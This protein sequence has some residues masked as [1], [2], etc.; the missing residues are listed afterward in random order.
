MES[1]LTRGARLGA[2]VGPAGTFVGVPG[3]APDNL[4]R[5]A[6]AQ[7]RSPA[8]SPVRPGF[9]VVLAQHGGV[10]DARVHI[11]FRQCDVR[12]D[13]VE[14]ARPFISVAGHIETALR[15]SRIGPYRRGVAA[16]IHNPLPHRLH[17]FARFR[18]VTGPFILFP[19]DDALEVGGHAG[20]AARF[21]DEGPMRIHRT[22]D[23][24]GNA[25]VHGAGDVECQP[26][27]VIIGR[28]IVSPREIELESGPGYAAA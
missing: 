18:D 1:A 5:P 26:L 16:G 3:A 8:H 27:F 23:R 11:A 10:I 4:S 6:V 17:L 19:I 12:R 28:G 9:L 14:I 25:I 15:T 7:L 22:V 2:A 21:D 20:G 13:G 24:L